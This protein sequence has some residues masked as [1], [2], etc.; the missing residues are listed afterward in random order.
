MPAADVDDG[1]RCREITTGQDGSS[2][3]LGLATHQG[4][5][6]S[7]RVRMGAQVVEHVGV[8]GMPEGSLS[9]HDRVAES[10]PG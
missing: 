7:E 10:A 3:Q 4:M 8:V 9:V 1:S 2:L 6:R 5:E